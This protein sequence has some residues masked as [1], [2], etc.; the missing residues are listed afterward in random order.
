ML[1]TSN[2]DFYFCEMNTR[3]QVEHP[4]SE[5]IT[6]VDLV[7]WQ[8]LA[9]S[10]LAIPLPT[11]EDV[12]GQFRGHSIEARVYAEDTRGGFMPQAGHLAVVQAPREE[13]GRLRVETGVRTGDDVSVHYDPMISKLVVWGE[14]RPTALAK[15]EKALGEYVIIGPPNNLEFCKTCVAHPKFIEGG[16][17]TAFIEEHENELLPPLN[18]T[19]PD[20]Q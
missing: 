15:L 11:Q 20:S 6:G 1:D 8:I 2:N 19:W 3:L 16:V 18:S 17:D 12:N 7:E 9:A 14:D 4:V 5:M 13:E 10:G